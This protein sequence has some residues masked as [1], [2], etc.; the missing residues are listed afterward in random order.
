[1]PDFTSTPDADTIDILLTDDEGHTTN[2]D[3]TFAGETGP[4]YDGGEVRFDGDG[5]PPGGTPSSHD[6]DSSEPAIVLAFDDGVQDVTFTIFDIDQNNPPGNFWDDQI[7]VLAYDEDNNLIE[8]TIT[9]TTGDDP[10][11]LTPGA[12]YD[13]VSDGSAADGFVATVEGNTSSDLANATFSV[14]GAVSRIE[15]FYEDGSATNGG[16]DP[17]TNDQGAIGFTL[18]S[19]GNIMCFA[20][21]TLI[22]CE[23]G[24][25]PIEN[26]KDGDFVHTLDNGLQEIRWIGHRTVSATNRLAPVVIKAGALNNTEDLIVSPNHRLLLTGWQAELLFGKPEVLVAAK[27]LVNGDT[28]FTQAQ[29]MVDYYHFLFDTHQIVI[30]NGMPSESFFPGDAGL[31]A[32]DQAA[33][34]EVLEIFPELRDKPESYGDMAR[35]GLRAHECLVL[36]RSPELIN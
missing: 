32:L 24:P 20:K 16:G 9:G 19:Y 12:A 6:Y 28:I 17:L 15:I 4:P 3:I 1:M 27:H 8:I 23:N 26:L 29:V 18:E 25:I 2:M 31:D 5:D 33:K 34:Q 13:I 35:E 21:G 10:D 22:E 7:R 30:A 36:S 11:N 14:P